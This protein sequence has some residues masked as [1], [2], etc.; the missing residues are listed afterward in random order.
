MAK[1]GGIK[2]FFQKLSFKTGLIVLALCVLFYVI[3]FAQM[4]LNISVTLKTVLWI[5]F[6]GLA[7]TA[8]YL[9]IVILGVDGVRR[10]KSWFSKTSR[11]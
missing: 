1:I 7:K 10:I 6:F 3:S 5:V 2:S 11:N 9:A 8:Q 4:S